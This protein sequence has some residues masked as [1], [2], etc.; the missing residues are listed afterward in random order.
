M[1]AALCSIPTG[2]FINPRGKSLPVF[3]QVVLSVDAAFKSAQDNDYAAVHKHGII[4]RFRVLLNRRTEHLGYVASK[5][6]IKQEVREQN[7]SWCKDRG[8]RRADRGQSERARN[9]RRAAQ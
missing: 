5:Q 6:P 8:D 1:A 3:D 2:G 4:G 9:H 7:V